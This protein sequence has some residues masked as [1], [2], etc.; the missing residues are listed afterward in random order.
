MTFT[1]IPGE[2]NRLFNTLLSQKENFLA[3]VVILLL[4]IFALHA[5]PFA[6]QTVA[7]F[8]R[9]M[10]VPGWS[11]VN[12]DRK[13]V[14]A[15]RS[16]ILDAQ[17]PTWITLKN[18]IKNGESPF[19]YPNASGG[20]PI[21]FELFN[22]TFWVFT[23]IKDNAFAYYMVGLLKLVISGFGGYLL[24][25]TFLRWFPSVFGGMVYMLCGFN[26][27]WFFWDQIATAMWIPWLLWAT[28]R[29]L[30]TDNLKWLP[31]ITIMSLLLIWGAYFPVAAYGF[32]SFALLV[33]VW[34]IY[35]IFFPDWRKS[36]TDTGSIKVFFK[37]S[38]LP[39]LAVGLAF[40]MSA[41]T[42]IPFIESMSGIN[43]GYRSGARSFLSVRD[44]W[45][46]FSYEHPPEVERTAYIGIPA[47]L[48]A[49]FGVSQAF[50]TKDRSLFAFQLFNILLV[51]LTSLIAFGILPKD[52]VA[53]LPV[54]KNNWGNRVIVV[55]LL[56]C[57]ALSAIGPTRSTA[58]AAPSRTRFA[59]RGVMGPPTLS[60]K[61][62]F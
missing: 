4:S 9:L 13:A 6:G 42:L 37:K 12:S 25:K 49:I 59:T 23:L 18:Q 44:L 34:N 33:L 16:D 41:V 21:S 1:D 3:F 57:A 47:C 5:N 17:L 53:V 7:P 32:Y 56:G 11:S 58:T 24:L 10:Q 8:D 48:L 51:I 54:F 35:T 46:F 20:Q 61:A 19:W 2:Q 14:H 22:P 43:L 31:V 55:T 52:L 62:P 38:A 45:L 36:F 27:A 40:F 60:R 15:D 26:A 28:V 50:K 39:L 30:K 29:Y